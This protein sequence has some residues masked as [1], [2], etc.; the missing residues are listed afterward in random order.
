MRDLSAAAASVLL[1]LSPYSPALAKAEYT[2][3]ISLARSGS[4]SSF[5]GVSTSAFSN[6]GEVSLFDPRWG[7]LSSVRVQL[8]SEYT[9]GTSWLNFVNG[10]MDPYDFIAS[11]VGGGVINFVRGS[12]SPASPSIAFSHSGFANY[13]GTSPYRSGFVQFSITASGQSNSV[14]DF[15]QSCG[16]GGSLD[17]FSIG[18]DA[19]PGDTPLSIQMFGN[20]RM[21]FTGTL[22]ANIQSY[23][24]T[25]LVERSTIRLTYIYDAVPEPST[26]I[27]MIMG[28]AAIGCSM[29]SR[30]SPSNGATV[31]A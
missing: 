25:F 27:A 5:S 16:L 19:I 22:P 10:R 24:G 1:C 12:S 17:F 18:N 6:P 20:D 8:I 28:F 3:D 11:I 2:Q 29:R 9:V 4:S 31:S 14:C 13:Q 26:W 21:Q 7:T 15:G 23:L 30:R